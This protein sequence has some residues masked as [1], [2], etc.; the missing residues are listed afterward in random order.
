MLE[1]NIKETT[2]EDI[3][4]AYKTKQITSVELVQM[5]LDR[6]K[7]YDQNG[8]KINS[9]LTVNP[10]VLEVAAKLDKEREKGN[11]GP[12]HGIPVILKDN[13]ETTDNMP[14]TAGAI[15]LENNFAREDAFITKQL[16]EAGAIILGKANLSEW[17][18]FMTQNVPSGYSS[19]GGQVLNPYGPTTFEAGHVGG[20]S[21]GSGASI[22]SNFAVIGIGTET[23]GSI[24]SPASSNSLVGI[25]PT[26]GLVSR[27]GIIPLAHSQD[28][29]GPMTR[30]VTDAAITLGVLAGVDET[31]A[32][33]KSSHGKA[34][35]DYTK[36]LKA[37]SLNGARIGVDKA[38]LSDADTDERAIID[39]AIE[40]IKAQGAIIEIVTIATSDTNSIVLWHEFKHDINAYLRNVSD[41]VPVK[42]L[43][44]IIE[45]NKQDPDVRMKFGQVELER[46][47]TMSDDLNDPTYV[48]H[49]Q[50]GIRISSNEGI[51]AVMAK[52]NLDALL[53]ENNRGAAMPAT[54]GYPSITVPAGYTTKGMPVGVTFTAMAYS[55]PKLIEFAYAYEQA[56][57]KRVA[58]KF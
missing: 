48:E 37:D 18:Y 28:T 26:V 42:S 30:T 7:E 14:T 32:I 57:K 13:I 27:T 51:D 15:A 2:I 55:E 40:D 17:A 47:Q 35:T 21:S 46:A 43:A 3:Q 58:P 36:H 38:F 50:T 11:Y 1:F 6:I 49:H 16:R 54:A 33:T 25:K 31:D 20:S 10:D 39:A 44:D 8:P 29:A 4:K 23:S 5:Y 52:H 53:F 22:A 19:L 12:L 24:L 9:I 34:L 56:T 45:F 41:D